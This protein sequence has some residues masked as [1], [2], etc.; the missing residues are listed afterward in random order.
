MNSR[1]RSQEYPGAPI[2]QGKAQPAERIL[3]STMDRP[4]AASARLGLETTMPGRGLSQ[5]RVLP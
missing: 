5:C 2:E 1:L 3:C 4:C